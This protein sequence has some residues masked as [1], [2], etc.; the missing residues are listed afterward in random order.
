MIREKYFESLGV[1]KNV[2]VMTEIDIFKHNQ[3]KQ[4]IK[5]TDAQVTSNPDNIEKIVT[6]I[7]NLLSY[8]LREI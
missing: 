6:Y 5:F 2:W 4:L 7:E 1:L 3:S 8:D